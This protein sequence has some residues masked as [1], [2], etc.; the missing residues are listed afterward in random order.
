MPANKTRTLITLTPDELETLRRE[1]AENKK[2]LNN[3]LRV[4]IGL[5]ELKRGAEIGNKRNPHGRRR[6]KEAI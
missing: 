6:N 5:P 4:K 1:A 3:Y 2:S